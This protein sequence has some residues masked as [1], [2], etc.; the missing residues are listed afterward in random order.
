[1]SNDQLRAT[2]LRE[3]HRLIDQAADD[4]LTRVARLATGKADAAART[5]AYPPGDGT[6][7]AHALTSSE[8]EALA[9]MAHSGEAQ[10]ALRKLLRDAASAPLF[11][12]L[13]LL[14]GV[15]DPGGWEGDDVW[16]GADLV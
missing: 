3:A 9:Q 4:A 5:L 14:D 12:F 13:C 8:S 15:G 10:R 6:T 2:L 11:H 16:L 1:M 7:D